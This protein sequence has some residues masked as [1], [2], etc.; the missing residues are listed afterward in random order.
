MSQPPPNYNRQFSFESFSTN[1][2][3]SQQPGNQLDNELNNVGASVNQVISRLSELQRADGKLKETALD[4]TA[5][6]ANITY[7]A[8]QEL[9]NQ[10]APMVDSAD[11]DAA[12]ALAS[13][14]LAH[15]SAQ[16]AQSSAA[17]AESDRLSAQAA[18]S[19]A[20]AAEGQVNAKLNSLEASAQTALSAA[21]EANS[22]KLAAQSAA[23]DASASADFALAVKTYLDSEYFEVLDSWQNLNDVQNKHQAREH[24]GVQ[25]DVSHAAL[26]HEFKTTLRYFRPPQA[27]T[28]VDDEDQLLRKWFGLSFNPVTD[29]FDK[30][31]F[32]ELPVGTVVFGPSGPY[33]WNN[34]SGSEETNFR[35]PSI[36]WDMTRDQRVDFLRMKLRSFGVV[37]SNSM[38][39]TPSE[40]QGKV[41]WPTS[42]Y[43][44]DG[45][46]GTPDPEWMDINWAV[47]QD[48]YIWPPGTVPQ[49]QVPIE[50]NRF[51][52]LEDF[53]QATLNP[54]NQVPYVHGYIEQVSSGILNGAINSDIQN[55]LNGALLP[56]LS[57][58][59]L[60]SANIGPD[61]LTSNIN[62][63]GD[64]DNFAVYN[65]GD[66]VKYNN[67]HYVFR[68]FIGA[69]GYDPDNHSGS[70]TK[71][72][73]DGVGG[74]PFDQS[75]NTTDS[76]TFNETRAALFQTV[77]SQSGE[78]TYINFNGITFPDSTTQT[79][80]ATA[81]PT[82]GD[83]TKP[84]LAAWSY[85]S[86]TSSGNWSTTEW[87]GRGHLFSDQGAAYQAD[88]GYDVGTGNVPAVRV[89][90]DAFVTAT[91]LRGDGVRFP[92]G[93]TQ[94]TAAF[95]YNQD[96]NTNSA[97]VWFGNA[98]GLIFDGFNITP[99]K[100]QLGYY[101]TTQPVFIESNTNSGDPFV[102][103]QPDSGTGIKV[104]GYSI[105]FPDTSVQTTAAVPTPDATETVAGKVELATETETLRG[106]D[107]TKVVTVKQLREI[108]RK[109]RFK[110]LPITTWF[111]NST[112]NGAT[113]G[114]NSFY[115]SMSGINVVGASGGSTVKNSVGNIFRNTAGSSMYMWRW[116]RGIYAGFSTG[117]VSKNTA[118]TIY[119][120]VG[121][122][123][124]NH[125]YGELGDVGYTGVSNRGF[126]VCINGD[127]I[128]LVY[129]NGTTKFSSPQYAIMPPG[130][131]VGF[132]VSVEYVNGTVTGYLN[133]VAFG[134]VTGAAIADTYVTA[135]NHGF[136]I[137]INTVNYVADRQVIYPQNYYVETEYIE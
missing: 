85:D 32:S 120:S 122:S 66:G 61:I 24:L 9:A 8:Y 27:E 36:S 21:S 74:N 58:P 130:N 128:W 82:P 132:E 119:F 18:A 78:G 89:S 56:S 59:F 14:N 4:N 94:T 70:W 92:D 100:T 98:D 77:D 113:A 75:L 37:M 42:R 25:G 80:A 33:I 5:I 65:A 96:L 90:M 60:T 76:P 129:Y 134:S 137:S 86:I 116:S 43:I 52:M 31:P 123:W 91:E 11:A 35:W 1:N 118:H 47:A 81:L 109:R 104:S 6:I 51:L 63:T 106:L 88:F 2:P 111:S 28:T 117:R 71:L 10:I 101:G 17:S 115:H 121:P 19:L 69:A 72:I 48:P 93:T 23:G 22:S 49:L 29:Q 127:N 34:Q 13:K 99:T 20:Q 57:N 53:A 112:G 44:T 103:I 64:Y 26:Y 95:S 55:A 30:I 105:T 39:F 79:T 12:S 40:H 67:A 68:E 3:T 136:H 54:S 110:Q 46:S 125:I 114:T 135:N 131:S 83:I 41:K 108:F 73:P 124:S 45:N 16:A 84:W 97:G 102:L 107:E 7:Q 126:Q 133:G 15:N 38:L 87:V 50:E 62:W